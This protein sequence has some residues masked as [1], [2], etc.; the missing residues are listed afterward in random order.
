[1]EPFIGGAG[2]EGRVLIHV[3]GD[4]VDAGRVGDLGA[5]VERWQA[6]GRRVR[7]IRAVPLG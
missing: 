5:E 1:M 2:V 3:D 4:F 6:D 7:V